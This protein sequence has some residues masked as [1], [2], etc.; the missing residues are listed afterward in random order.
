M[1]AAEDLHKKIAYQSEL[2]RIILSTIPACVD[3]QKMTHILL[4]GDLTGDVSNVVQNTTFLTDTI[5]NT[6]SKVLVISSPPLLNPLAAA[7]IEKRVKIIERAVNFSA[8][9]DQN[10]LP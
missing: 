4:Y 7:E 3:L 5:L 1:S 9:E 10:E 6:L 2:S 8:E